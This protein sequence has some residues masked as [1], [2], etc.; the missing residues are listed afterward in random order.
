M[1][2]KHGNPTHHGNKIWRSS[3]IMMD[4]LCDNPPQNNAQ[5][6]DLGC[7]WGAV[8]TLL[9]RNFC[10]N[11]TALDIDPLMEKI[12]DLHCD[13]NECGVNF[14]NRNFY[15][16]NRDELEQFELIVATDICF[17]DST[18]KENFKLIQFA[19]DADCPRILIA[20][21]GRPP[22]WNLVDLCAERFSS[23]VLSR[24]IHHHHKT[25]GYVLKISIN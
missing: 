22:F 24:A 4:Y 19:I 13:L 16:L 10:A 14:T 21:P 18:L 8:S 11:V 23:E 17:W 1:K 20:D 7:G 3:L 25:W 2:R 5:V 15:T 9:A 6:L 12:V